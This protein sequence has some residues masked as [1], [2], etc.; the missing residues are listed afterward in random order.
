VEQRPPN[1]APLVA[2]IDRNG[3]DPAC[4]FGATR[5]AGDE[6]DHFTVFHSLQSNDIRPGQYGNQVQ[7]GPGIFLEASMFESAKVSK[8]TETCRL[9]FHQPEILQ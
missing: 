9:N 6:S 7:Q 8:V 1:P 5:V 4:P 3:G 2:W